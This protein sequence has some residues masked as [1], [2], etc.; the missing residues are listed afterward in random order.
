MDQITAFTIVA[1]VVF[2]VLIKEITVS[3]YRKWIKVDDKFVTKEQCAN[4][5]K[6]CSGGSGIDELKAEMSAIKRILLLFAGKMDVPASELED[7]IK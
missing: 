6:H 4:N 5:M 7:L 2:S 1:A 3:A